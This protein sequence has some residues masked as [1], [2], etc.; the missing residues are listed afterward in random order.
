MRK[1]ISR[2]TFCKG[3]IAVACSMVGA[4]VLG[5]CSSTDTDASTD[6]ATDQDDA[7]ADTTEAEG[8]TATLRRGYGAAHGERSYTSAVV[9]TAA[10]GTILAVNI[11]ELQF[12]DE[13]T[14]GLEAVPNADASLGENFAEGVVL[15]SKRFND[16]VYFTSM[17]SS[18]GATQTW[19]DSIQAIEAYCVGK[20]AS[21]LASVDAVSGS[22]LTDSA[23]YV[24][25][26]AE[27][28]K[29]SDFVS[30]GE[31]S[32][33]ADD[34]VLGRAYFAAHGESAFAEA[35]SLVEDDVIV[36]ANIDEFQC[37][38]SDSGYVG[39]PNSDAA[40]GENLAEGMVLMSKKE[41]SE[42][43]SAAMAERGGA[44][45]A[46][47]ENIEA[48]EEYIAGKTIDEL[49]AADVDSVS[50]ATLSDTAGYIATAVAA[51]ENA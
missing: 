43:Y 46:Y 39:V 7:A 29:S 30:S 19:L 27:V 11:D 34:L 47:L 35:A 48:I 22:T 5:G 44:T 14:E 41:N 21:E 20:T 3:S 4:S 23:N 2:R 9:A 26:V 40:F 49:S 17:E 28:A 36:A 8:G 10:D 51:A 12:F 16:E 32:G 42:T 24:A 50:G 15:A 6:D 25:L 37:S 38:S 45:I 13:T 1:P 18:G 33:S 31:Y